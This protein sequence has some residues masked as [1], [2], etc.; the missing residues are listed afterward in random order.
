MKCLLCICI[1]TTVSLSCMAQPS[2]KLG[3]LIVFNYNI[4]IVKNDSV[5]FYQ[6][7]LDDNSYK[8]D[9]LKGPWKPAV[10]KYT[11]D[12][13]KE[14][15]HSPNIKI[16]AGTR[17][18][19]TNERLWATVSDSTVTFQNHIV[20][21]DTG[22]V[23]PIPKGRPFYFLTGVSSTEADLL[24]I[25]NN[26]LV[27]TAWDGGPWKPF[28]MIDSSFAIPPSYDNVFMFGGGGVIIQQNNKLL[29]YGGVMDMLTNE[30]RFKYH[31]EFDFSIP[32]GTEE[33]IVYNS[34]FIGLR[35][36]RKLRFYSLNRAAKTWDYKKELDFEMPF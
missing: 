21:K 17:Q 26:Q 19:L 22:L 35:T 36:A 29:L 2:Q 9:S 18:I 30:L 10:E 23:F 31:P 13:G 20:G 12:D 33:V 5:L 14:V 25:S 27:Y 15:V 6:P 34:K 3:K 8:A 24:A 11:D 32:A 28:S 7:Q 1:S 4:G 16:P